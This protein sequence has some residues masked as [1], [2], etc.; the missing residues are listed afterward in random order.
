LTTIAQAAP[1]AGPA[2]FAGLFFVTLSTLMYEVLLTR[3]FSVTMWYHFAFVAVSVALF[4]LTVGALIV[5]LRPA[6]FSENFLPQR[7]AQAALL[8][9]VTN[10]NGR[11]AA[12]C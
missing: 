5:H 1:R 4:G 2:T 7:L 11:C 8:F 10:R 9:S 3:I 6:W 12:S